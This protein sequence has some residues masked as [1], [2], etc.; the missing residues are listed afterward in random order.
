VKQV[1]REIAE[2]DDFRRVK[3][4]KRLVHFRRVGGCSPSHESG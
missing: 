4:M 1:V 2:R 3:T